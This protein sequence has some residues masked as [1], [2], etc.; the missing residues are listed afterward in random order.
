MRLVVSA[1]AGSAAEAS[2]AEGSVSPD[3][4]AG[5]SACGYSTSSTVDPLA[6]LSALTLFSC[7]DIT[8]RFL[9]KTSILCPIFL[10]QRRATRCCDDPPMGELRA[11]LRARTLTTGRHLQNA[12]GKARHIAHRLNHLLILDSR[13][14][15]HRGGAQVSAAQP[16]RRADQYQVLHGGRSFVETNHHAHFLLAAVHIS[17]Q[18]L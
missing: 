16:R 5:N 4:A 2:A 3:S 17:S 12:L 7:S 14:R 15:N 13:G 10:I 9:R 1:P 6:A 11:H 18:Q 8:L